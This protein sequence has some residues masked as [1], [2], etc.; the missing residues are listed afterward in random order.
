MSSQYWSRKLEGAYV[1]HND[2]YKVVSGVK[3]KDMDEPIDT[4][5]P[6]DTLQNVRFQ[7]DGGEKWYRRESFSISFPEEGYR[8]VGDTPVFAGR[9]MVRA[10]KYAP[11][12]ESYQC[13]AAPLDHWLNAPPV[14]PSPPEALFDWSKDVVF[15]PHLAAI[16]HTPTARKLYFCGDSIANLHRSADTISIASAISE[17]EVD[18]IKPWSKYWNTTFDWDHP[19][20]ESLYGV[21]ESTYSGGYV[22]PGDNMWIDLESFRWRYRPAVVETDW[23]YVIKR[24]NRTRFMPI[25]AA[26]GLGEEVVPPAQPAVRL[27]FEVQF[28]MNRTVMSFQRLSEV[29]DDVSPMVLKDLYHIMVMHKLLDQSFSLEEAVEL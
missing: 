5:Y 22:P 6:E 4:R 11:S 23:D 7:L 29:R 9:T 14:E 20:K 19:D 17:D 15:T 25:A 8:M 2:K 26:R 27:D 24:K 12:T 28:G 18:L 16:T 3:M 1:L 21:R 10:W 13:N